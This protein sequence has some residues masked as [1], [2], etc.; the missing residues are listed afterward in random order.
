MQELKFEELT[1][2]QK[3]GLVLNIHINPWLRTPEWERFFYDQLEKRAI[4]SVWI[5]SDITDSDKM[6]EIIREKA[7]YPILIITDAE[8]GIYDYR[9]GRHNAV[10]CAGSEKHAYAFGKVVGVEAR[11]KGYDIVCNPLLDMSNFGSDRCLGRKKEEVAKLAKAIAR[12]LHDAGILTV[13]K[14]YPSP[15][16]D[17]YMDSHM[18]ESY[19]E[20]T[21]EE[22]IE[23]NLYPYI[24]MMKE[25]LLDG[26][27]TTHTKFPNIDPEY[28]ASLSKKVIDIIR[29]LGF[30]G[31]AITDALIMMGIKAKYGEADPI[32]LAIA[33]G[34]DISMPFSCKGECA[35]QNYNYMLDCYKK[36]MIDDARLDEAV[37]RVLAAQHKA[38]MN[39]KNPE[40]TAEEL[41]T[42]NNIDK[43]AVFAKADE[44]LLPSV[45][46]DG[47]HLFAVMV[48]NETDLN[49]QR[50]TE[51]TF[52]N[53]WH[54]PY[55]IQQKLNELFPNS[56]V[57]FVREFPTSDDNLQVFNGSIECEDTI[58]LTFSEAIPYVGMERLTGRI[59]SLFEALQVTNR[60][61]TVV[62]FGNPLV[63][64]NLPHIPR[65]ILGGTSAPS[66]NACIDVLAG[67]YPAKGKLTYDVKLN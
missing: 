52:T 54:H 4:G 50:V 34:N 1:V 21:K 22:L 40:Y 19:C 61:S 66:V 57:L 23:T 14:H 67:L 45:S 31:F 36:G 7:D 33:A 18:A 25:D 24:E 28:P 3:L 59:E 65:Y 11:K 29:E 63:L 47:K 17:K 12:G 38:F 43:D 41:E 16:Q 48:R 35:E 58:F 10:G 13:G 20:Q 32:G 42:F 15:L 30:D 49:G 60:V 27:M 2:E 55:K 51:D 6:I 26:I 53:A 8:S 37:K 44:G 5:Q 62:H 46:R 64:G 39:I 9:I 56:K